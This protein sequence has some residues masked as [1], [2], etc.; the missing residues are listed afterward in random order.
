MFGFDS[1]VLTIFFLCDKE[2]FI[3]YLVTRLQSWAWNQLLGTAGNPHTPHS[4]VNC[5]SSR[6]TLFRSLLTAWKLLPADAAHASRISGSELYLSLFYSSMRQ[7]QLEWGIYISFCFLHELSLQLRAMSWP[8]PI[9]GV[10]GHH[11]SSPYL[12]GFVEEALHATGIV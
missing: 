6:A 4:R 7:C 8:D 1:H 12:T 5:A 3:D 11:V 10:K 9:A 2:N